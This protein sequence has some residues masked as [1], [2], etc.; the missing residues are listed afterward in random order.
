MGYFGVTC[1]SLWRHTTV[2]ID[3]FPSIYSIEITV[4]YFYSGPTFAVTEVDGV[5]VLS[6]EVCDFIQ[7]V[8]GELVPSDLLSGAV[9]ILFSVVLI[10]IQTRFNLTI[11]NI[12]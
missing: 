8:P 5:R 10:D 4:R 1:W 9:L 11:C 12:I 3:I 6:P 7:K 2:S